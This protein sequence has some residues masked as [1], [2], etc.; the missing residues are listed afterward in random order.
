MTLSI[1]AETSDLSHFLFFSVGIQSE[2]NSTMS[3]VKR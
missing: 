3:R 1:L 2:L